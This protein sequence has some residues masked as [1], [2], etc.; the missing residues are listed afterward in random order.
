M[1]ANAASDPGRSYQHQSKRQSSSA[2]TNRNGDNR[3]AERRERN[4]EARIAGFHA[5]RRDIGGGWKDHRIVVSRC[6]QKPIAGHVD[7]QQCV[8]IS[9]IIGRSAAR[10]CLTKSGAHFGVVVETGMRMRNLVFDHR[11]VP[12][13]DVGKRHGRRQTL[14]TNI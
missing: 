7:S 11:L 12:A 2:E 8:A 4:D 5:G 14:D 6:R 1:V 10:D 13:N 3:T 9:P